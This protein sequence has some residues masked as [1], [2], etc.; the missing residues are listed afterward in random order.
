MSD[1]R[2]VILA[3]LGCALLAGS[4]C[5]ISPSWPER[6]DASVFEEFHIEQ[7]PPCQDEIGAFARN[8]VCETSIV[9]QK[10]GNYVFQ[11]IYGGLTDVVEV[12]PRPLTDAEATRMLSLF[13]DLH[14]DP[15][16]QPFCHDPLPGGSGGDTILRWD[17]REC[18]TYGCGQPRLHFGEVRE[19]EDFLI[20][21][22][23]GD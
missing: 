22:V 4:R 16:N 6:L 19:I 3:F 2:R 11:A 8:I 14:Y 20:A 12:P 23:E 1:R 17:D 15:A 18:I 10:R 21:L 9:K 5:G 7:D 13:A